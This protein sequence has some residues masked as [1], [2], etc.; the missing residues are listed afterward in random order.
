MARLQHPQ[1][2]QIYE[3]GEH[4][5]L[6]YCS[7]EYVEGG[8][9][10]QRLGGIP[11]PA[12][13]AAETVCKLALAVHAAH[14]HGIVHR[15]LKPANI[16]LT[17]AGEPKIADFGLAKHLD[18]DLGYTQTG[19]PIGTPSYMAVEQAE[20]RSKD[21]GPVTD[22]YALGAILYEMLTGRPPFRGATPLETL[23]QVR[24]RDPVSPKQLQPN[25]P[26]DLETIC[27]KALAKE[28]SRRYATAEA[29]AA[30]LR[31]WLDGEPIEARA[32]GPIARLVKWTRRRPATAALGGLTLAAAVVAM[33]GVWWH[34]IQLQQA[35]TETDRARLQAE[36]LR[37]QSDQQR[38]RAEAMV[39]ATDVR[40]AAKAFIDGDVFEATRGLARHRAG[41]VRS[42][43]AVS[44]PGNCCR[45][46]A[47]RTSWYFAGTRETCTPSASST[48]G[49][50][51]SPP[52]ATARCGC[53]TWPIRRNRKFWRRKTAS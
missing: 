30:D 11:Q 37:T 1:I 9:L 47:S 43:T 40:L 26:R 12:R 24:T 50:G 8:S 7:L 35:L 46:F 17:S 2:V 18:A 52:G 15:D 33:I 31:R 20:G 34:T 10:A 21:I 32:A 13:Q 29:L 36:D 4:N 6:P 38:E 44:S 49:N 53:G 23:E 22:V 28:S 19:V 16:L 41:A 25:L 42:P 5:G 51:S 45:R 3:V 39:Y 48:R 14:Q 27:L